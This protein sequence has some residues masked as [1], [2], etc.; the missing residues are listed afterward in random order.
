[1]LIKLHWDIISHLSDWEKIKS[2]ANALMVRLWGKR[3]SQG[4][5]EGIGQHISKLHLFLHF[6]TLVLCYYININL[7]KINKINKHTYENWPWRHSC[8]SMKM[9][10]S[11]RLLEAA[12]V[13]TIENNLRY[14]QPGVYVVHCSCQERSKKTS[15][16]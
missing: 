10:V 14:Q 6:D 11:P 12:E 16:H 4:L 13:Q 8:S 1:M 15:V 3:H 5:L 9:Y 2:I 7:Y